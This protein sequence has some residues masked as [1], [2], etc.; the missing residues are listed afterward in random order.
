MMKGDLHYEIVLD[1]TGRS[2][3]IYFTDVVRE[4]LPAS[5]ASSVAV[6]IKRP[7]EADEQIAM[8]IDDSPPRAGR[9]HPS[10]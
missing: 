4:D 8:A 10:L 6:T 2:H 7:R 1:P 3:R 5:I 9:R